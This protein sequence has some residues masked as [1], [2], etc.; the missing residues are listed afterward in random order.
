METCIT[1][2]NIDIFGNITSVNCGDKY[3]FS[4]DNFFK[5][6]KE[7]KLNIKNATITP[8]ETI[9][10][11]HENFLE[12][13]I[14]QEDHFKHVEELILHEITYEYILYTF[15]KANRKIVKSAVIEIK[16]ASQIEIFKSFG[17]EQVSNNKVRLTALQIINILYKSK[18]LEEM[19]NNIGILTNFNY[20][21]MYKESNKCSV[22][23]I[24]DN[25]AR[26]RLIA[27]INKSKLFGIQD[28]YII[29]IESMS[30]DK[31]TGN[32]PK[33]L[34]PPVK[35]LGPYCFDEGRHLE[36]LI[37]PDTVVKVDTM[38]LLYTKNIELGKNTIK[39]P[40]YIMNNPI[41]KEFYTYN[42]MEQVLLPD[43]ER[44]KLSL[45]SVSIVGTEYS[46]IGEIEL[47]EG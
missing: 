47:I 27:W 22:K 33:P 26:E 38:S 36:E 1:H 35:E 31:Y 44:L 18:K 12:T 46:N 45:K 15:S 39:I 43:L 8:E 28:D 10:M 14:F 21:V 16:P 40:V 41:I 29:D 24:E 32:N 23:L 30:L 13:L 6:C 17:A 34:I 25:S 9:K 42:L 4:R 7:K 5:L 20:Y 2:I 11:T 37:L 3:K 19:F